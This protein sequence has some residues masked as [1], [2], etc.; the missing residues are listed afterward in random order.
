MRAAAKAGACPFT[1]WDVLCG[2]G[3]IVFVV[4]IPLQLSPKRPMQQRLEQVLRLA[5]G[6]ALLGTQPLELTDGGGEL[7]L[8]EKRRN[9]NQ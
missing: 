4:R 8:E 6:F 3:S 2:G 7:L 5:L 1:L 9:G